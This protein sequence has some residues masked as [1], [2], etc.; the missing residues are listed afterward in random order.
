MQKP[1][2]LALAGLAV[3]GITAAH[4]GTPA[5]DARQSWQA[6]RIYNGIANGSLS[7]GEAR[8][9][10]RGQAHVARLER[11]AKADGYVSPWERA[12][13]HV[14]QNVQSARI[15]IKKHN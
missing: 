10:A 8:S 7:Y 6:H 5:V 11:I 1:T 15:W 12:R 9:L 14:A 3:A 2:L 13:L 4:A